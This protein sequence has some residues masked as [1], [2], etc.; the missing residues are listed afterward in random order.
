MNKQM[1]LMFTNYDPYLNPGGGGSPQIWIG[2]GCAAGSSEPIPMFRGNF[3][4]KS[5][6]CLGMVL[7]SDRECFKTSFH[8]KNPKMAKISC[9]ILRFYFVGQK[10]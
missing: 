1:V 4:Q 9:H 2:W 10:M 7:P 8:E 3:S 6:P 5:Y